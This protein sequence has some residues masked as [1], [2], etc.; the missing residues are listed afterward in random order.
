[1][2]TLLLARDP[3]AAYLAALRKDFATTSQTPPA[4]LLDAIGSPTEIE[5]YAPSTVVA[6]FGVVHGAPHI[7]LANFGGLS[8]TES[9]CPRRCPIF[10]S[11][12][13]PILAM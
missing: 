11:E 1:V 8:R 3:A 9:V 6:Y 5:L 10:A 2:N 7:F 12:F 4:E 13:G